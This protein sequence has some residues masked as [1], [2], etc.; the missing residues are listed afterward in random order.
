VV[1]EHTR[2]WDALEKSEQGLSPAGLALRPE[3][4]SFFAGHIC[5]GR[6]LLP[7][8]GAG[9]RAPRFELPGGRAACWVLVRDAPAGGFLWLEVCSQPHPACTFLLGSF[10]DKQ[11]LASGVSAELSASL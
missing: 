11:S 3:L 7:S 10:V 9:G 6:P 5:C 2:L 1:T 4:H 8:R